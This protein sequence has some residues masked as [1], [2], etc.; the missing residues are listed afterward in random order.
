MRWP[1]LLSLTIALCVLS[2]A[3]GQPPKAAGVDVVPP[4][5]F[6]FVTVRVSDLH[7]VEALK[8]VREAL[9]KL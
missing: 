2:P 7:Q 5:A 3:L 1:L 4:T 9:S 8:P 6:G